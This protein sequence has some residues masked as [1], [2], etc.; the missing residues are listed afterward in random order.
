MKI[1]CLGGQITLLKKRFPLLFSLEKQ[2]S[3][4]KTTFTVS[5]AFQLLQLDI[6]E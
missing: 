5:K 1:M 4:A 2:Y 6:I 3:S